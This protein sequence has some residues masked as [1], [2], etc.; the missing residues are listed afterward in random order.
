MRL[1]ATAKRVAD[2]DVFMIK[3]EDADLW[4]FAQRPLDLNW[5]V[6]FWQKHGRLGTL[7]KMVEA[8]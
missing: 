3:I 8:A 4:R 6:E 7:A 2:L 1:F 5:L